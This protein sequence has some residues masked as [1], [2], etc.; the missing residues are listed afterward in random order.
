MFSQAGFLGT[1]ALLFLDIA[2]VYFA[3]LPIFLGISISYA[4]KK[5][6][7]K[8]FI[9]QSIILAFTLILV[10][11]FEIGVRLSGGF[12]EYAK[13]SSVSYD[14]LVIFLIV[15]IIIAIGSVGGWLYLYISAFKEYR[16]NGLANFSMKNHKKIG[17]SI[18]ATLTLSSIMGVMIYIFLFVL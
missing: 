9:S 8:H 7:K 5:Q 17:K 11:I 6:Y 15:H 2:T 13:S 4:I 3:L 18:F 1:E 10:I 14:F 12:M 16:K